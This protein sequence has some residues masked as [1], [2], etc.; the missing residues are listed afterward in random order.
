M[1]R[2]TTTT[3]TIL[4]T[5]L[6]MLAVGTGAGQSTR[7]R[8]T[9]T[10][11]HD[12][13]AT[14]IYRCT[15]AGGML[16][17]QSTPCP[18]GQHQERSVLARPVDPPPAPSPAIATGAPANPV[19]NAVPATPAA[20]PPIDTTPLPPPPLYRCHT[21]SG[22]SYVNE[23]DNP[24]ERCRD[25]PLVNISSSQ[26]VPNHECEME[27]DRCERIPDQELCASWKQ[28]LGE[29][30]SMLELGNPD[31]VERATLQR[32]RAERVMSHSCLTTN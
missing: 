27:R 12:P 20:S 18:R 2:L 32:D 1:W 25:V 23:T 10:V 26:T 13:N 30:R 9:R 28:R 31:L 4:A 15:D 5:G 21:P 24:P 3:K 16:S 22:G 17:I 29:A 8:K 6:L 14:V 11:A 7:T 19:A